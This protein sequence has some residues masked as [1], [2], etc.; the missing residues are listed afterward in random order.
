MADF[1]TFA[2]WDGETV[3]VRFIQRSCAMSEDLRGK[4]EVRAAG[5]AASAHVTEVAR[6]TGDGPTLSTEAQHRRAA[7][8]GAAGT[9]LEYYEFSIYATLGLL[10]A[11]LFFPGGNSV[12]IALASFGVG[13]VARPV[14][15]LL[16][17]WLGD[18]FGRRRVL[19]ATV[20]A[21]GTFATLM[22]LLPTY[23][24]IGLAAPVLLVVLRLLQGLSAGGELIGAVT[25]VAE[26]ST[27]GR[28]T[29]SSALTTTGS[30]LGFA[31]APLVTA[32]VALGLDNEAMASWGWRVPFLLCLPLTAGVFLL[33][34][35]LAESTEFDDAKSD[36][37]VQRSPLRALVREHRMA[38]LRAFGIS[39][40]VN[41]TGYLALAYFPVMLAARLPEEGGALRWWNAGALLLTCGV[42]L[43]F[44]RLATVFGHQRLMRIGLGLF[45]V[46]STPLVMV[47]TTTT[48]AVVA[49]IA[50]F[51][52]MVLVA[53]Q[54][55]TAYLTMTRD[56]FPPEVRF[57]G[58]AISFNLGN[59]LAGG[60]APLLISAAVQATGDGIIPAYFAIAVS[61]V[62][63][64]CMI[65]VRARDAGAVAAD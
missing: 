61:V 60:L 44:A 58:A 56:L 46:F 42:I 4:G 63:L 43:G 37:T 10:F 39:V 16:A 35:S 8:A 2:K 51:G 30:V 57:S 25:Y 24:Q 23:A 13:Y 26:S 31:L 15:G 64:V 1:L 62:G 7:I 36:G 33:R 34:R 40:A 27:S 20:L 65:G 21:M 18:R 28:R 19:I 22:G 49:S 6:G 41:G 55:A 12:L 59:V 11:P 14:G 45:A 50:Y 48:S 3:T 32:L 47:L 53:L 17:G 54:S 29:L 38:I 5:G 52:F 9:A